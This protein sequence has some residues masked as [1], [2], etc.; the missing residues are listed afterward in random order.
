M[1]WLR[2]LFK[3]QPKETS[4]IEPNLDVK[5]VQEPSKNF[6]LPKQNP[7]TD[8]ELEIAK[9]TL[10]DMI[11]PANLSQLGGGRPKDK[12]DRFTSWWGGNFLAK[13]DEDIPV[14]LDT[15]KS[16]HPVM[17][18][19]VSELPNIPPFLKDIELLTLWMSLEGS[20]DMWETDNGHIFC[21]RTY[22]SLEELVPLGLGY[23]EHPT[24][25]SYPIFWKDMEAD[26]PYWEDFSEE[27][28]DGIAWLDHREFFENH[29]AKANLFEY[30]KNNPVKVGGYP[31]WWQSPEHDHTE[32]AF[33]IEST[34]KGQIGFYGGT[35]YFFKKPSGWKMYI[36]TC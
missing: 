2:K 14:C 4:K 25:P 28:S 10:E 26:I 24:F 21:I 6:Y 1:N 7:P 17:Q 18:I 13:P 35:A 30:Q 3:H 15:D 11:R 34:A 29:P 16:M 33:Q 9:R 27:I 31:H 23:K 32:F 36:Q 19:K 5:L 12:M 8:E 20:D 22:K